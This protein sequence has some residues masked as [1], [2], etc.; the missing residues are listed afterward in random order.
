MLGRSEEKIMCHT[1]ARFRVIILITWILTDLE[2]IRIFKREENLIEKLEFSMG[3]INKI[4]RKE[5][6]TNEKAKQTFLR[7]LPVPAQHIITSFK[8]VIIP[9]LYVE[10]TCT[11]R[12]PLNL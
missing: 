10:N 6:C 3:Q 2:D 4:P 1:S 8:V 7:N 11:C 12:F 5:M 9:V